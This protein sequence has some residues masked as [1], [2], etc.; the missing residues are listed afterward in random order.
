MW[1]DLVAAIEMSL[2]Y[3]TTRR[4][5]TTNVLSEFEC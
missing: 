3:F 2:E 5:P 1:V 4:L